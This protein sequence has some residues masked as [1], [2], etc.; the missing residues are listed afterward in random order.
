MAV[1]IVTDSCSDIPQEE[2]KRL[3]ITV[4]PVYLRFGSEVYRDGVDIDSSE[5]YRRLTTSSVHP[6]TAAPSPGDFAK[7]YE[8]VAQ[9]TSEIVS[10]H[11]TKKHSAVYDAAL[12]GKEIAERKGCRIEVVDSGGVTMWQGLIAIAAAKAAEAGHSLHQVVNKAHETITQLRV[13]ALLDTLKYAVKGGRL[14]NAIFTVESLLSVKAF[15]TLRDG[16]IRPAGLTRSRSKGIHRLHRF[17]SSV[18]HVDDLAIVHSTTPDEAQT[19]ADYAR[20]LFPNIVPRI[21]RLGP[22]LGVHAGP[23]ALVTVLKEN[24]GPVKVFDLKR[25]RLSNMRTS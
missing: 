20:S 3:G 8:E 24:R 6:S 2:A 25:M 12:L 21:S 5:F 17:I 10:I 1:R 16:E 13:L 22:A 15:L 7:V 23:G 19:L 18:L 4:I 14:S 11:V 9:K